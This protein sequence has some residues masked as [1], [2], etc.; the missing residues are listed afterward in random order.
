MQ[1]DIIIKNYRC[2]PD[3]N[4]LHL[5]VREGFTAFVG[6][7]N[8]GKSSI[9]RFFYEFRNLF[10][11]I[12]G[13]FNH[14]IGGRLAS[15]DPRGIA[16][17]AELFS[18]ENDRNLSILFKLS[19]EPGE[20]PEFL[21][22]VVTHLHVELPRDNSSCNYR[23]EKLA[24]SGAS[25]PVGQGT[26]LVGLHGEPFVRYDSDAFALTPL[27][28]VLRPISDTVYLASF[29]NA[30]NIGSKADYFDVPVG[31]AFIRRW[32]QFKSG[33]TKKN[34]IAA[35]RLEQ[36]ICRLFG[37]DNLQINTMED[38]KS[39]QVI[40]D[41]EPFRLEELGS[42]LAQFILVLASLASRQPDF[43]LLDEPELNL[44]PSLQ[45][46]FLTTIHSYA[47]KGVLF[48]T[49]SIGLAR[50]MSEHIYALKRLR[51]GVSEMR[52]LD[53]VP[54]LAEFL[55]ELSYSGYRELGFD[56]VLLVEGTTDVKTIQ[57]FLRKRNLDHKI[58]VLPLGG[59]SLINGSRE[60]ELSEI[61]R[62]T[63]KIHVL[64]DSERTGEG[65]R[66][67]TER[68]AFIASCEKLGIHHHVLKRR[69][70]ENYLTE[71]AI[72]A[73][74]GDKY[75]ALDPFEKLADVSPAWSKSENW[76]IAREMSLDELEGS[77]LGAFIQ[78][79]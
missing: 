2:F 48:G 18:N 70:T 12:I 51:K 71:R 33:T 42:G 73:V 49:H 66:L 56:K 22:D 15:F 21:A 57:Q 62:I 41:H 38:A 79:L 61:T 29:R 59:S 16:D 31:E 7:N 11:Q 45:S 32:H 47:N 63:D 75:R 43:V 60:E 13:N 77:D 17:P 3:S 4:P 23:V 9:L 64:I 37:F 6:P 58:V 46:D 8:S 36:D 19:L 53:S 5:A 1:L 52:P 72:K 50:T 25:I 30:I 74:K 28:S 67:A 26:Q 78:S 34:S 40:V 44:H 76:R 24:A 10:Q 65:E 69:A 14:T 20:T 55:G 39:L 54:R 68:G 27:F 35:D